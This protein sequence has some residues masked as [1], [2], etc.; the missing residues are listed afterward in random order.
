M[1]RS[2]KWALLALAMGGGLA[3]TTTNAA[4]SEPA[5]DTSALRCHMDVDVRL[6]GG[7]FRSTGGAMVSCI[8]LLGGQPV[9][10]ASF[11]RASGELEHIHHASR[12]PPVFGASEVRLGVLRPPLPL[13]HHRYTPVR[14]A[15][16]PNTLALPGAGLYSGVA[17]VRGRDHDAGATI[18][19][20]PAMNQTGR[21]CPTGR[22]SIDIRVGTLPDM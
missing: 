19:F 8:G 6:Q 13:Q 18:A 2:G 10:G 12:L 16:E 7:R 15:L 1:R 4:A 21:C 9:S 11:S 22:L 5:D 14:L 20:R 17:S 3:G